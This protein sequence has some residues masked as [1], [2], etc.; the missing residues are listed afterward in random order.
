MLG[1]EEDV[2]VVREDHGFVG[3]ERLHGSDEVGGRRVHRLPA[4]DDGERSDVSCEAL[5]EAP[6]ALARDDGDDAGGRALG[7]RVGHRGEQPLLALLR[8]L[9]HVRDLD[10]VDRADRAAD[11]ERGA[12]IV[13]VH[14][15]LDR[16]RVADDEQR[17][18]DLL[19]LLL[20][21]LAVEV[22]PSIRNTVQ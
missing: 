15:H 9:V 13:G 12:G 10:A 4:L 3:V 11:R 18:A 17:V 7:R 16:G 2:R 14:V 22:V 21:R 6:V 5:E 1:G 19:E 20:E 8:L